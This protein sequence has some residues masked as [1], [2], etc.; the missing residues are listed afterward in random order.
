M[1]SQVILKVNLSMDAFDP[2]FRFRIGSS[3]LLTRVSETITS[4]ILIVSATALF[5]VYILV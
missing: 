1:F 4:A 3:S 2:R 5:W